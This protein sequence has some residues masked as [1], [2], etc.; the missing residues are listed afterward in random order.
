MPEFE[1]VGSELDLFAA[2]HHWKSYWSAQI[3]RFIQGDVL[4]VGAGIGS[5]TPFLDKGPIGQFVCLEPDPRLLDRLRSQLGDG[6]GRYRTICGALET[7][8]EEEQFDT[9]VYIDVLEHIEDDRA[10]LNR[11]A[12]HLRSG[13]RVIVLSP[14]HHWLFTPFDAAIGHFRRYGRSMVR[15]I[16]PPG[17]E[18]E[19]CRYLDSVGL[20]ASAANLAFLR[21]SMPTKDQLRFWDTFLIPVSRLMDRLLLYSVGKSVLAVWHKPIG[22]S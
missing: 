21:Q 7:L 9:I 5:N 12:A 19:L 18:L 20:A 22:R 3:R 4:E 2:V 6:T 14:A 15:A 13:G 17:L 1:Y 10:E 8:P 16:S 11:A